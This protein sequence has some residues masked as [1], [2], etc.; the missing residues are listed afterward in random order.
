MNLYT[1][2]ESWSWRAKKAGLSIA[3]IS[4]LTGI[5]QTTIRNAIKGGT[6]TWA[7]TINK[8]EGVLAEHGESFKMEYL[9]D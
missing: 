9:D 2:T 1:L 4:R 7:S 6:H 8:I 3:D 5:S